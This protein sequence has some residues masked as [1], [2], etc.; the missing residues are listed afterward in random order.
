MRASTSALAA[1][2]SPSICPVARGPSN[3]ESSA[4]NPDNRSTRCARSRSGIHLQ[5]ARRPH[6]AQA[7]E[8]FYLSAFQLQSASATLNYAYDARGAIQSSILGAE[9]ALKGGILA[10]GFEV[11]RLK[12]EFGLNKNRAAEYLAAH[13]PKFELKGVVE[14]LSVFPNYVENR[15]S[16]IQPE[17]IQTGKIAMS[18]QFIAGE[19]MRSVTNFSIA[20][21][22]VLS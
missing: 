3:A 22:L 18:A 12:N 1:P 20:S 15:Y 4:S 7:L 14:A 21:T 9:L 10:T 2:A 17:R 11:E 5:T 16:K 8:L 13:F 6:A 19:V